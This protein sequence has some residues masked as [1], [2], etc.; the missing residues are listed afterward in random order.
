MSDSQD[1]RASLLVLEILTP[2]LVFKAY[3]GLQDGV[4]KMGRRDAGQGSF[5]A[6]CSL[7]LPRLSFFD[8]HLQRL[9]S[10]V[11]QLEALDST[12]QSLSTTSWDGDRRMGKLQIDL[13]VTN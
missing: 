7:L 2:D 9:R 3:S 8:C 6:R 12:R 10:I 1:R 5:L 11:N 4:G 13:C